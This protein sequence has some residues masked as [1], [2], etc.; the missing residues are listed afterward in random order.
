MYKK[1]ICLIQKV[2]F[3]TSEFFQP[4]QRNENITFYFKVIIVW[5]EYVRRKLA[6]RACLLV[7]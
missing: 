6:V 3:P 7:G 5:L 1:F 4:G 2:D